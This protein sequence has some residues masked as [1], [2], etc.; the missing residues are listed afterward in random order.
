MQ[1]QPKQ[2]RQQQQ[3]QPRQ[4]SWAAARREN[5][6]GRD[7]TVNCL[8]YDPFAGL[9]FDYVGGVADVQSKLLRC[10]GDA[11]ERFSRDPACMLR[12]VRC[13]ARAGLQVE[14][15]TLEALQQH[16]HLVGTLNSHRLTAE[17]VGLLGYG[18]AAAS[19]QLLSQ[20]Q[21]L[22]HI[23]PLHDAYMD[24]ARQQQQQLSQQQLSQ[25]QLSQQQLS[26]QQ[27]SQQQVCGVPDHHQAQTH[28]QRPSQGSRQTIA[29]SLD[30]SSSTR[31]SSSNSG[32]G[33]SKGSSRA[34]AVSGDPCQA[35]EACTPG[36]QLQQQKRQQHASSALGQLWLGQLHIGGSQHMAESGHLGDCSEQCKQQSTQ[37][38]Q[39][40]EQ[41][42]QF[43]Q[44]RQQFEQ[45]RQQ[46]QQL[47]QQSNMLLRVLSALD[48]TASV[49]QPAQPEVVLACLTAP[50]L[51]D[52]LTGAVQQLQLHVQQQ[53]QQQKQRKQHQ[54]QLQRQQPLQ[55]LKQ[56]QVQPQD[57]LQQQ[58]HRPS[59][60]GDQQECLAQVSQASPVCVSPAAALDTL[61][62]LL[63]SLPAAR[64]IAR[65]YSSS[66]SNSSSGID[67]NSS[68][69]LGS[70]NHCHDRGLVEQLLQGSP[71]SECVQHLAVQI[72]DQVSTA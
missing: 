42:Q 72:A 50:L 69:S 1:M 33:R 48:Q 31:S 40:E 66:T 71:V 21:L 43:E 35:A 59:P 56:G 70:G 44:Q 37:V 16:S 3:L 36:Q 47:Q 57:E 9:L 22:Q 46:R 67:H 18:A 13:A 19:M 58:D 39:P 32:G 29:V 30:A 4:L 25:Q 51:H 64:Q 2:Q 23:L 24:D 10:N 28:Q 20:A 60:A 54:K 55:A 62:I 63:Q 65:P 26:Q 5:A 41:Q 49:S 53:Q 11:A 8:L 45:Q 7:F 15:H 6:L 38:D 27:L 14:Q 68:S 12:A 17:L 61:T 52:A 34:S